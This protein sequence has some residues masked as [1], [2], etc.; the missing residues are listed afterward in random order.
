MS[1]NAN[2][3]ILATEIAI[4]S[5]LIYVAPTEG[6]RDP[7]NPF[8]LSP[9][10]LTQPDASLGVE[11]GWA[12]GP[13]ATAVSVTLAESPEGRVI[14]LVIGDPAAEPYT[15]AFTLSIAGE[16]D[17]TFTASSDSLE[18]VLAGWAAEIESTLTGWTA[19]VVTW[20]DSDVPDAIRVLG[21]SR[22]YSVD[23]GTVAPVAAELHVVREAIACKAT[24]TVQ[25]T[26]GAALTYPT[27][28]SVRLAAAWVAPAEG[29][30]IDIPLEGY[31][32]HYATGALD[33]VQVYL[34]DP[35]FNSDTIVAASGVSGVHWLPLVTVAPA[36]A[37]LGG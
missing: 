19:E 18:D 4:Q 8:A 3:Q 35:G 14:Y 20:A 27:A 11:Q 5:S 26:S 21:D 23:T 10:P 15:G 37:S 25:R 31:I 17:A 32:E 28:A 33:R 12:C 9:D 29:V 7:T 24:V 34:Y 2:N 1:N 6:V 13:V 30:D 36:V 22:S 16:T